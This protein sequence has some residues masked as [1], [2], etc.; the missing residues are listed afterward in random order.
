[1]AFHFSIDF[2]IYLSGFPTG[3]HVQPPSYRQVPYAAYRL[4]FLEPLGHL[5][6]VGLS[7]VFVAAGYLLNRL[8]PR[9]G[10]L[11]RLDVK[12]LSA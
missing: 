1:M 3:R 6:L 9:L 5:I 4:P 10:L 12:G 8:V 7:E 11:H 2:A